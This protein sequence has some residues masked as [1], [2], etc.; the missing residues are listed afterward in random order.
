MA[1]ATVC[2]SSFVSTSSNGK[3]TV[4]VPAPPH[5]SVTAKIC[6]ATQLSVW[7]WTKIQRTAVFLITLSQIRRQIRTVTCCF[8]NSD[9]ISKRGEV[10][11]RLWLYIS[12]YSFNSNGIPIFPSLESS[13][14]GNVACERQRKSERRS[15]SKL[16]VPGSQP[17]DHP[18]K[19]PDRQHALLLFTLQVKEVTAPL[20]C[21]CALSRDSTK[22]RQLLN[23][24]IW[25]TV[26][27]TEQQTLQCCDRLLLS[28]WG[29][30]VLLDQKYFVSII[31]AEN[32]PT[33]KLF[34]SQTWSI[35][36]VLNSVC[37]R[38]YKTMVLFL[39]S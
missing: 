8:N 35:S 22:E 26:L 23:G 21:W 28:V 7:L 31:W 36:H 32:S 38:A 6:R 20:H 39:L 30:V 11:Q 9:Y 19:R 1:T 13:L 34:G 24:S 5:S 37:L 33:L 14:W 2:G 27:L 4:I 16:E 18:S 25:R 17:C 3:M 10:S 29:S 15:E 12:L